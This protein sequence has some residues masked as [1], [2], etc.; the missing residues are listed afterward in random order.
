M[1]SNAPK[2]ALWWKRYP[3]VESRY[4]QEPGRKD[5]LDPRLSVGTR[6]RLCGK[7]NKARAILKVEWHRYRY[8]YVYVV[9]AS[10]GS[11]PYWF[12]DQLMLEDEWLLTT[13][14]PIHFAGS[15]SRDEYIQAMQ[16]AMPSTTSLWIFLLLSAGVSLIAGIWLLVRDSYFDGPGT[17][18]LL[19][20]VILLLRRWK[21]K[22]EKLWFPALIFLTGGVMSLFQNSDVSMPELLMLL[23]GIFW[24]WIG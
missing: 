10:G 9:E 13:G 1:P 2:P 3:E 21:T 17:A 24:L 4:T 18:V 16:M 8:R 6:V 11:V 12:A 23:L 20:G 22:W 7:P 5:V 15:P 14:E 19:L